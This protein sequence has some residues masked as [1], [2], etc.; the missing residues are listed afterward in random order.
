MLELL[1]LIFGGVSRLG[2]HWM[3]LK[4]KQAERDHEFRMYE[5]QITLADKK[6]AHEGVMRQME[7]QAATDKAD[8][9]GLIAAITAQSTEAKAAG[10]WV[11]QI[12]ALMRPFLTFWHAVVLYTLFKVATFYIAYTG[13]LNW[14]QALTN[15]YGESDKALCFSMVSFWFMDRGLRRFYGK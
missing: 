12:S 5:Q 6:Y 1:G 8:I 15:I 7:N 11:A 10:G 3:D 13:G 14:A 2:Q 4:E 9:D